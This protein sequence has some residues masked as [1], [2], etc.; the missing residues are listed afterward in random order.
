MNVVILENES[1]V[2]QMMKLPVLMMYFTTP[3]C[4]VCKVLYPRL[5]EETKD[6]N[7]PLLKVDASVLKELAG[8]HLVLSVPTVLVFRNQKELLRQSRYIDFNVIT[9]LL[10]LLSD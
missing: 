6:Y 4:G 10:D 2:R 8:Q 3:D 7:Y 9:R 1:Q 5:L